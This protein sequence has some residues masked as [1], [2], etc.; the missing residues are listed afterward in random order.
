MKIQQKNPFALRSHEQHA[1][2]FSLA[3]P[4]TTEEAAVIHGV[5]TRI[6]ATLR[7]GDGENQ[8]DWWILDLL[9]NHNEYDQMEAY[10]AQLLGAFGIGVHDPATDYRLNIRKHIK[11][12]KSLMKGRADICLL[13]DHAVALGALIC[14]ARL[15]SELI[16]YTEIGRDVRV[17]GRKGAKAA[18]G[19]TPLE[20]KYALF[21]KS[22]HQYIHNG[23]RKS[24]A[25]RA[26]ARKH[27]TTDRTIRKA[28][29]GK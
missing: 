22:F 8:F 9:L 18:H 16:R 24:D 4:L 12:L 11:G 19:P 20:E 7:T 3:E 6:D 23:L 15:H 26:A 2:K 13:L 27:Q 28:V 17:G 1:L 21:R 29:T 10:R 25:Y 5:L 14:E